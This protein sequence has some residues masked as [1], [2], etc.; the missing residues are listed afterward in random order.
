MAIPGCTNSV[1]V[2]Y[3]PAAEV[4][5]GSCKYLDKVGGICYYWTEI[6]PNQVNNLGFT[7]SYSMEDDNWIFYHDYIPD[8]YFRTKKTLHALNLGTVYKMNQGPVPGRFF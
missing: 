1:A 8:F 2:N 7:I 4:D 3:N 6:A 5:D